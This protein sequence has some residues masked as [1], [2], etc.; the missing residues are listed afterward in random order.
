M[1]FPDPS[2]RLIISSMAR[3]L[4]TLRKSSASKSSNKMRYDGPHLTTFDGDVYLQVP[5][6]TYEVIPG[7]LRNVVAFAGARFLATLGF[8]LVPYPSNGGND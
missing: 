8:K 7:L 6:F 1:V 3:P 4:R 5:T 2:A